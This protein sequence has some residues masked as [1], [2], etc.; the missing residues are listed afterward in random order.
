MSSRKWHV[1]VVADPHTRWCTGLF[2]MMVY[3]RQIVF[4]ICSAS[5]LKLYIGID[6]QFYTGQY[7]IFEDLQCL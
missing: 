5:L 2:N 3:V 7:N 1:S 4:R 6:Q